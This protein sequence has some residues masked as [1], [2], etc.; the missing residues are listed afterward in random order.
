MEKIFLLAFFGLFL[1]L[2]SGFLFDHKLS[3]DFPYAYMAS[4]A[5]QHQT[6]AESIKDAGNY[7]NEASYIVFGVKDAI[8][9][10]PPVLY[11]L[12]VMLSHLSGLE[13]YD[14]IYFLVF[15]IAGFGALAMYFVIRQFNKNI[16]IISLPISLLV[17]ANGLYTGFTWGHWPAIAAQAFLVCVFWYTSRIGLEK[18]Y[19]FLAIFMAAAFMTHT[20]E[21]LFAG[22]YLVIF[23]IASVILARKID[24][25]LAKNLIISGS[26]CLA[27]ISYYFVIFIYV[28]LP[29]QAYEFG[30]GRAWDNPTIYLS[31]FKFFFLLI[32][33]GILLSIIFIKKSL[34]PSIASLSMIIVGS[35]NYFG[36]REKA[37]QLRFFWPVFLSFF[38]GFAV[39]WIL[40]L[41]I[42]EW[43]LAYSF[44]LSGLLV[45]AIV[46]D[47]VPFVPHYNAP[48]SGSGIMNP[49]H[50]EVFKWAR[51]STNRESTVYFF[52]GDIY[53]QDAL[54]RNTKRTHYQVIP[55]DFIDAI[56]KKEIRR[57]YDTES[58]GDHG[59]GVPYK[60]SFL[61]FGSRLNEAPQGFLYGKRDICAYDYYVFDKV[62]RQPV[63]AQYNLLIASELQKNGSAA[64]VF[65]NQVAIIMKNSN[66]G[67]DCIEQRSF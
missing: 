8:G 56:N 61:S 10:Y 29:R 18:S 22:I 52:Y 11:D 51:Q 23:Y 65:E 27:I 26:L 5:F 33:V 57:F 45:A 47:N 30:V 43:K 21:A 38:I 67:A 54:L 35:G 7:R 59:G 58:P 2:G 13:V 62:S 37:F 64:V 17:F 20:S 55:E 36:F 53:G 34:V 16:A 63:L 48:N 25:K 12:S 60:K 19:M 42:K 14:A 66:P 46:V 31:D 49:Y 24:L 39:Y 9:Y 3:H 1:Y 40:K 4:D 41:I 15:F 50:W 32:L 28:W 6:R 44:I